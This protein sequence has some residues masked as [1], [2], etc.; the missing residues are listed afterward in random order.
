M[1]RRNRLNEF[2]PMDVIVTT[3]AQSSRTILRESGMAK[4]VQ[5]SQL[6]QINPKITTEWPQKSDGI[7]DWMTLKMA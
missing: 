2:M 4:A 1:G 7:K 5:S 3:P 6:C